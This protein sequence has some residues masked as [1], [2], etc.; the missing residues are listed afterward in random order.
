MKEL[1]PGHGEHTRLIGGVIC[2]LAIEHSMHGRYEVMLCLCLSEDSFSCEA[3]SA[4][5]RLPR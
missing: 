5:F 4:A 3:F 1:D 2:G